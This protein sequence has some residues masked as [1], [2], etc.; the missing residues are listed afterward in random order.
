MAHQLR[1]LVHLADNVGLVPTTTLIFTSVC[2]SSYSDIQGDTTH[3]WHIAIYAHDPTQN[4]IK[5]R[6]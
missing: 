1:A 2:N 5:K 6:A 3:M 4:Q